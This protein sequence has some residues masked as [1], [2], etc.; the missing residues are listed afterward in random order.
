MKIKNIILGFIAVVGFQFSTAQVKI[1]KNGDMGIGTFDPKTKL[2]VMGEATFEGGSLNTFRISPGNPRMEIGS[3]TNRID[4]LNPGMGHNRLYAKTFSK[5]SDDRLKR[6]TQDL[7]DCLSKIDQL[8]PVKF[9]LLAEVSPA[10]DRGVPDFGFN[11]QEVEK[12][13]PEIITD[14]GSGMKGMDYDALIPVLTGAIQEQQK[15]IIE[16]RKSLGELE[17]ILQ[18]LMRNNEGNKNLNPEQIKQK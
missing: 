17:E 12:V 4:F 18:Q 5:I 9:I 10:N 2:H 8:R 16:L 6:E 3:S 7:S 13:F 1:K 15:E 14:S 11:T